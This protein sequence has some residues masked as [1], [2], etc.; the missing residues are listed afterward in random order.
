ML[1]ESCPQSGSADAQSLKSLTPADLARPPCPPPTVPRTTPSKG[2]PVAPMPTSIEEVAELRPGC[3][4]AYQQRLLAL[5]QEFAAVTG[6]QDF[7]MLRAED[8]TAYVE[9][10]LARG[11]STSTVL[12]NVNS[13]ACLWRAAL[14]CLAR[15]EGTLGVSRLTFQRRLLV[16]AV[17]G[18]TNRSKGRSRRRRPL[19]TVRVSDARH[20][21]Q[22]PF[23]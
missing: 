1:N 4:P 15:G 10:A 12:V 8:V 19:G 23:N 2:S 16:A 7:A 3:S 9:A 22:Q 21:Q 13:L 5:C 17:N 14:R 18:A 6:C 11:L 20:L